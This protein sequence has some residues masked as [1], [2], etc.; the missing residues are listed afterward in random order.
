MPSYSNNNSS[1]NFNIAFLE[2]REQWLAISNLKWIMSH[3]WLSLNDF[4]NEKM[5]KHGSRVLNRPPLSYVYM[6][7]RLVKREPMQLSFIIHTRT[8]HQNI[9]NILYVT[10]C[11]VCVHQLWCLLFRFMYLVHDVTSCSE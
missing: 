4:S 5:N 10:L 2:I 7:S 9:H 3:M 6:K 8:E 11:N 1:V